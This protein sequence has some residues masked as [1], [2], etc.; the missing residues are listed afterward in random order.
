M[1]ADAAKWTLS[2]TVRLL[3]RRFGNETIVY[4]EASGQTHLFDPLT[5]WL[6]HQVELGPVSEPDLV[7]RAMA[8]TG[9]EREIT[10]QRVKQILAAFDLEGLAEQMRDGA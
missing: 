10:A 5:D 7:D 4:N 8:E 9:A 6:L 1:S 3:R 2:P